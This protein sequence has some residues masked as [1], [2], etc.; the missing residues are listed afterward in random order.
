MSWVKITELIGYVVNWLN[1]NETVK[2]IVCNTEYVPVKMDDDIF[3]SKPT[4][5][6]INTCS[7]GCYITYMN[8]HPHYN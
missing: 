5:L 1:T 8:C 7:H 6:T 4:A 3:K 2:C